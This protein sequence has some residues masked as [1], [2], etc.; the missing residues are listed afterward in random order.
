MNLIVK[1]KFSG[2]SSVLPTFNT[3]FTN[4]TYED[5]V[6]GTITTRTIYSDDLP[7]HISF[8][9]KSS[10]L[11]ILEMDT[12][13]TTNMYGAFYK[14]SNL[15]FV[16]FSKSNF[17]KMETIE[18][19]FNS[20]SKL[21]TIV[22]L[23]NLDV[24]NVTNMGGLFSGCRL[25]T[26][27]DVGNWD[28]SKVT[29]FG[30]MF[31]GCYVLK[32]LDVNNWNTNN[33]ELVAG[34]FQDCRA[35]KSLDISNWKITNA[36]TLAQI[37]TNCAALETV[38]LF[39]DN[40]NGSTTLMF[41]NCPALKEVQIPKK[42]NVKFLN[43][44]IEVLP[45]KTSDN[46]G[47]LFVSEMD[48]TKGINIRSLYNKYWNYDGMPLLIAQYTFDKSI[49]DNLLPM[50]NE[51]FVNYEIVDEY[52][53]T[54]NVLSTNPT[55]LINLDENDEPD[56]YPIMSTEYEEPVSTHT[57]ENLVTRSIYSTDAPSS[58]SFYGYTGLIECG[59][60]EFNNVT[61]LTS[62]F[63]GC[64]ALTKIDS[65]D[66][67]MS[68]VTL[69]DLMFYMC[70][71]LTEIIGIEDWDTS[72]FGLN[73]TTRAVV[74]PF[75]NCTS[76]TKLDLSKWIIN[77]N[78]SANSM[79]TTCTSLNYLSIPKFNGEIN[80][81]AM[82]HMCSSLEEIIGLENIKK[83]SSGSNRR[84]FEACSSLKRIIMPNLDA[85]LATTLDTMFSDCSSLTK[86]NM[87]NVI[88]ND[89]CVLN[90]MFTNCNSLKTFKIS[91]K[92]SD[93]IIN[94][95]IGLLPTKTNDDWGRMK[96]L[97]FE[98][99][100]LINLN[101]AES[102]YWKVTKNSNVKIFGNST[103]IKTISL[104]NRKIKRINSSL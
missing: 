61:A 8:Q 13:E 26:S 93:T 39:S 16:D 88:L 82:F 67:N 101:T 36:T 14:C 22:G 56:Q 97:G 10:L 37:F 49:Q 1:Y 96:I 99:I 28:V 6:D 70:S 3:E 20:C 78:V 25:L 75:A 92:N 89:S 31:R 98:D 52:L 43:K 51:E 46:P 32:E 29:N 64:S 55:L 85:S 102:K 66:W 42:T 57:A 47:R 15:K 60:M 40:E 103:S 33:A 12:R 54:Q 69:I 11:E 84:M 27:I 38:L 18:G 100:S 104:G 50:F 80:V 81:L 95:I 9:G 23:E 34:T 4:Y 5:I 74:A 58:I 30:A 94:T 77:Y 62:C 65:T 48:S 63:Q 76:L 19:M 44:I 41:S 90:P 87:D 91:G 59:Y 83:L 53:N 72:S 71:A 21:E 79:F 35:L 7:T 2:T 68:N 73:N 17:S 45:T 86:I 24:S